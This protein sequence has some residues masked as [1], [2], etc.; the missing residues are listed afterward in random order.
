MAAFKALVKEN[1][2]AKTTVTGH[3]L[4]AAMA[5]FA[6]D[7]L[8]DIFGNIDFFY[9][10][11]SPR[12]G[13]SLFVSYLNQKLNGKFRARITHYKDPV[14][15]LPLD[16]MGFAHVD[17]EVYYVEDSSSY[18]VC[19]KGQEDPNCANQHEI[20]SFE[21]SDHDNYIGIVKSELYSKCR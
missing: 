7:D 5:T 19:K 3:S 13:N 16:L 10:Y 14:P 12:V 18:I 6:V 4:G 11:G 17:N 2:S 15:H 9:T 1:P 20:I 21:V 8:I